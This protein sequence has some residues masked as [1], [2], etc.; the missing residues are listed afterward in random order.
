VAIVRKIL[1]YFVDF[2]IVWIKN[3]LILIFVSFLLFNFNLGKYYLIF[4]FLCSFNY[5]FELEM[6]WVTYREMKYRTMY[7]LDTGRIKPRLR[8]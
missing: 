2:E 1:S 8:F 7:F 5:S 3:V 4:Y 6:Y